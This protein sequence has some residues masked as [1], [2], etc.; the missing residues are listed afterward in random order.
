MKSLTRQILIL[1]SVLMTVAT[2]AE[3]ELKDKISAQDMAQHQPLVIGNQFVLPSKVLNEEKQIYIS[4][5]ENYDRRAHRYPVVY[6]VEAEFLFTPATVI[7][8]H[9]AMRNEI[10]Q[11]I[12][13]GVAN[14]EHIKRREMTIP[15]HGGKVYD[16]LD[17]FRN[18]LIPYID[19]HFRTNS[20][21]TIVGLS[22]TTGLVLEAFWSQPDLF[23]GYISLATHLTWPPRKNVKMIDQIIKTITD[24]KQPEASI[25]FGIAEQDVYRQAYETAAYEDAVAK[26]KEVPVTNVRYKLDVL[27]GEEHYGMALTGFRNGLKTI[28]P[29]MVPMNRLRVA[30]NPARAIKEH[31]DELSRQNGFKTY[32]ID[33]GHPHAENISDTAMAL[34]KWGKLKES[35]DVFRLSLEYFPN[36]PEILIGLAKVYHM[37]DLNEQAIETANAAIRI[38]T[39]ADLPELDSYKQTLD[40]FKR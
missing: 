12:I 20:H 28:Y 8:K 15:T 38:S 31:Y 29:Y 27:K 26:L 25:Y 23:S 11:S 16:H 2:Q 5:P 7:A 40:S 24:N 14:G 34:A 4:L 22:P 35:I 3:D 1:I 13:V 36:D 30:D 37:A 10:P 39:N 32:P 18:E 33:I 6:V 17:F 9:M 21:R 19:K